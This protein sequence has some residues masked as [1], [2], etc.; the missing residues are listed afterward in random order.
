MIRPI[1]TLYSLFENNKSLFTDKGLSGDFYID[2]YRG[3]T[4]DPELFEFFTLP[5]IFID[6]SIQGQGINKPR[7]VTLSLHILIDELP[8]E[9]NISQQQEDGFKRFIYQSLI[10]KLLEGKRLGDTSTL[11]FLS[12]SIMDLPVINYHIQTYS[13]EAYLDEMLEVP[14]IIWGEFENVDLNGILKSLKKYV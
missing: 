10:Q 1:V 14:E 6:Y 5:A 7:L 11:V 9:S 2:I 8:S 3:Q 13:F 4:T 12:E